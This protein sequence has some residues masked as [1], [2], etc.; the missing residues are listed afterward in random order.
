M[1][2]SFEGTAADAY[3]TVPITPPATVAATAASL[4]PPTTSFPLMCTVILSNGEGGAP[5]TDSPDTGPLRHQAIPH[6]GGVGA[7]FGPADKAD[8]AGFEVGVLMRT[9]GE[10]PKVTP[11]HTLACRSASRVRRSSDGRT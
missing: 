1:V 8:G 6:L 10:A 11:V 9:L 2:L 5:M 7:L 3:N 4:R